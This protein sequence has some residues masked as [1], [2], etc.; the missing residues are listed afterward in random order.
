MREIFPAGLVQREV[1]AKHRRALLMYG[2][3]HLWRKNPQAN[4]G[5]AGLAA[6]LVSLLEETFDDLLIDEKIDYLESL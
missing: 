2:V 1:L 5:S 4:F 3:G 6:S